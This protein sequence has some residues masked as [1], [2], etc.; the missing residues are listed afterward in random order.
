MK[1]PPFMLNYQHVEHVTHTSQVKPYV[2]L[3]Y[4][5]GHL[6]EHRAASRCGMTLLQFRIAKQAGGN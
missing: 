1:F 6:P 5:R 3:L 2:A 4:P